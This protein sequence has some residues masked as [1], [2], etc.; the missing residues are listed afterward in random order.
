MRMESH[1]FEQPPQNE[2]S[3]R[4]ENSVE[5]I[6]N[7]ETYELMELWLQKQS[8]HEMY[9]QYLLEKH[10][11]AMVATLEKLSNDLKQIE[12]DI[13]N[14][15]DWQE[16]LKGLMKDRAESF[17]NYTTQGLSTE[18]ASNGFDSDMS[19]FENLQDRLSK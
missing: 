8:M 3:D 10:D 18:T 7:P 6:S 1:A 16:S 13:K 5:T 19:R 9:R 15:G 17:A 4:A 2:A 11:D 12:A 14:R